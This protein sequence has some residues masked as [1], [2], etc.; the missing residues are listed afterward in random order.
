MA[1]GSFEVQFGEFLAEE[2]PYREALEHLKR[3]IA[4]IVREDRGVTAFYIGKGSGTNPID[5]I[6]RR[7]DRSKHAEEFTEDWAL[8]ASPCA[9]TVS[10]LEGRLN[11][12]FMKRDPKRCTNEGKGSGGAPSA[13]PTHYI[14][15]ALR[16]H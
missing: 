1:A 15:L 5:A 7:Y 12:Y 4:A 11:D 10:D 2:L 14:Y 3:S 13:Q 6:Y 8:Y 16:R 9:R